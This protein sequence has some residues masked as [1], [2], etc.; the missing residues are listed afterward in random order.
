M[1]IKVKPKLDPLS[2]PVLVGSI[3]AN[4]D[5][6]IKIIQIQSGVYSTGNIKKCFID[7]FSMFEQGN[8]IMAS[9]VWLLGTRVVLLQYCF[10]FSGHEPPLNI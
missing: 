9:T 1:S 6:T 10:L 2:S 7:F 8:F 5:G 3:Q 4:V